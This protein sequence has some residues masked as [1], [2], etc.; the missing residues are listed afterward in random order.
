MSYQT[1]FVSLYDYLQGRATL[2]T[3]PPE[4]VA[5]ANT[6][7][8]KINGLLEAIKKSPTVTSG[9]RTASI[10]VSAG[11]SKNSAHLTCEAIDLA[12]PDGSLGKLLL[13]NPALLETHDLYMEHPTATPTWVHLQTRRTKS[14]KR[15]FYP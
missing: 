2:A 4:L 7:I 11:G 8:P 5:N 1:K 6:L 13:N 12:D 15:V 9:Y 10:N 14:G 3:L